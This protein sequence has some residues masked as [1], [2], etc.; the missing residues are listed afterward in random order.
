M[1][2]F[3]L[4]KRGYDFRDNSIQEARE[5]VHQEIS[6]FIKGKGYLREEERLRTVLFLDEANTSEAIGLIKEIMIDG[7]L[8]GK[9]L[10]FDK[11][12]I[13]VIAACNPYRK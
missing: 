9:P 8:D 4:Y 7:R 6:Q 2:D 11:Y 3:V 12:G 1:E 10:R 5:N 13:D